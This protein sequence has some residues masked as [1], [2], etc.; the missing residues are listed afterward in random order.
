MLYHNILVPIALYDEAQDR[1]AIEIARALSSPEGRLTLLHVME[2]VPGYAS[3]YLPK[4]QFERT[5]R[6]TR[7]ALDRLAAAEGLEGPRHAVWGHAARTILEE[8]RQNRNDCIVMHSHRPALEDYF[9]G[10]TAAHVVRHA[11]CSV[12]V[13]R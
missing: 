13:I 11:E 8:A 12:H 9:I 2:E 1:R 4:D 10:S 6:D 3:T 7:D 5:A